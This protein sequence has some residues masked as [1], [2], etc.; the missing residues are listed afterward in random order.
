MMLMTFLVMLMMSMTFFRNVDDIYAI[1]GHVDDVDDLFGH[2]DDVD[3]P[4]FK[5]GDRVELIHNELH[6][7]IDVGS[8][9]TVT[10]VSSDDIAD[11]FIEI[12]LDW[13]GYK[14][15]CCQSS[16]K[17]V[18]KS[19]DDTEKNWVYKLDSVAVGSHGQRAFCIVRTCSQCNSKQY[20]ELN[21]DTLPWKS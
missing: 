9:G 21:V 20:Y 19:K 17:L 4:K 15:V 14:L 6:G 10:C 7:Y 11:D 13:S 12:K 3:T 18:E 5:V 8:H 1:I 16:L 2:V